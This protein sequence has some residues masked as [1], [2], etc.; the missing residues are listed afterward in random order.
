MSPDKIYYN[1][2]DNQITP[3]PGNKIK[4]V[5]KH[6]RN[7]VSRPHTVPQVRLELTLDGF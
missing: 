1:Q 4:E 3:N 2:K 5:S 7:D 6:N